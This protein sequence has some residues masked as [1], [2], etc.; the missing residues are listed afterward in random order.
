MGTWDEGTQLEACDRGSNSVG[1]VAICLHTW[2]TLGVVGSRKV[3]EQGLKGP[4]G[5]RTRSRHA[6]C[7]GSDMSPVLRARGSR[8]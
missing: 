4:E 1:Y 7:R 8:S 6:R 2:V 5:K 3:Q